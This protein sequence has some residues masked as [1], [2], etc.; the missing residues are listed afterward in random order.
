MRGKEDP[1]LFRNAGF[2]TPFDG[3]STFCRR[4]LL[5]DL[6]LKLDWVWLR[7]FETI[8]FGIDREIGLSDH[9]SL[10]V[11]VTP[12]SPKPS[13]PAAAARTF[14]VDHDLSVGC[15]YVV[16]VCHAARVATV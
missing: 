10:W 9:W 3:Q 2:E 12:V 6:K 7:G 14:T 1:N 5:F 11:V 13:V 8:R 15:H 4:L 16:P